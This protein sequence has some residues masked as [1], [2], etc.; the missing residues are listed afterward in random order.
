VNTYQGELFKQREKT[1][2]PRARLWSLVTT[3]SNQNCILQYTTFC[4]NTIRNVYSFRYFASREA[5]RAAAFSWTSYS[6]R[7]APAHRGQKDNHLAC[8]AHNA[9]FGCLYE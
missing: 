8:R 5:Y 6:R 7:P 3:N 9:R 4:T 2:Q 1:A